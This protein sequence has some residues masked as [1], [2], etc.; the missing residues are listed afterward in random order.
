MGAAGV[1]AAFTPYTPSWTLTG[2]FRVMRDRGF[3]SPMPG[4]NQLK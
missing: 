2:L 1:Q 4:D 3:A